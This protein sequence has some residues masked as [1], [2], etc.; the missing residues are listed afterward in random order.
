MQ[1]GGGEQGRAKTGTRVLEKTPAR[2]GGQAPAGAQGTFT[3]SVDVGAGRVTTAAL[4]L[5][6][7]DAQVQ[8]AL[9]TATGTA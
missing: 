2:V 5:T 1:V 4:S 8:A 6:S 7:T 3:L 9:R